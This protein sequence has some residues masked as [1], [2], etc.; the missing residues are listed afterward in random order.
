MA[1][2]KSDVLDCYS[3]MFLSCLYIASLQSNTS[4]VAKS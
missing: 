3:I 4:E 1:L 2:C